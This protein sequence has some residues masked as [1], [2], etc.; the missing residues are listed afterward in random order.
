MATVSLQMIIK[1]EYQPVHNMLVQA[2]PYFDKI[3]LAVSDKNTAR[4]LE[5]IRKSNKKVKKQLTVQYREWNN[6]FALS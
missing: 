5:A 1:D 3:N 4:L 6:N 2:F